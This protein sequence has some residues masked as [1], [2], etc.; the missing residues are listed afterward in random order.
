MKGPKPIILAIL[1]ILLVGGGVG[2]WAVGSGNGFSGLF[3]DPQSEEALAERAQFYWD[4]KIA[5]DVTG[6]YEYMAET[7]RRRVTPGQ[8]AKEGARVIRTGARVQE[9]SLDEKGGLVQLALSH[10]FDHP[11]SE[12][13]VVRR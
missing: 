6:A 4:L 3:Q 9:V 7:F 11:N 1:A 2:T 8:F 12:K 13:L 10:R 5:G